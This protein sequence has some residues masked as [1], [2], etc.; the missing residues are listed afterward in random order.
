MNKTDFEQMV[1]ESFFL[2][3]RIFRTKESETDKIIKLQTHASL[4]D[5]LKH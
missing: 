1:E 2:E 4:I 3:S 5:F